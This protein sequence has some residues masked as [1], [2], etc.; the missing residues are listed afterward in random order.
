MRASLK[1]I[2]EAIDADR[3]D[4]QKR[5]AGWNQGAVS[6]AAVLVVGAGALGNEAVK[7]LLQLGV[8][9]ITLVDYDEIVPAN[10][11]RCVFFSEA[12]VGK[13]KAEVVAREA[14]R[15]EPAA[16]ITV[17]DKHVE[18]VDERLFA[19]FDCAFGCLDNIGAR[20]HLNAQCYGKTPLVDGGTAAFNGRVQTVRSPSACIECGLSKRDYKL[21]WKKYSCVGEVLDFMDPKMPALPTTTSI[22]AAIQANEFLKI[23][24]SQGE[25]LENKFLFFDGLKGKAE[26]YGIPKRVS[27]PV[28]PS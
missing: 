1:P 8:R 26:L 5:V 14:K 4:R 21:L 24:F 23:L 16:E 27:C 11:N 7:N 12:D 13:K 6:G 2:V 15:L 9:K 20:L 28:H 10:L 25:T 18:H 22:I 17:I 3:H 19:S